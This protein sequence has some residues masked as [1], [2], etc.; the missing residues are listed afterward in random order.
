MN[1]MHALARQQVSWD[2]EAATIAAGSRA[3]FPERPAGEP[4][5]FAGAA[6]TLTML[7]LLVAGFQ[8]IEWI[9]QS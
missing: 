9:I 6:F 8:C 4:G 7:V 2:Q 3:F 1:T 5:M